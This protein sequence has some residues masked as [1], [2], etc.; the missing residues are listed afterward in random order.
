LTFGD[1]DLLWDLIRE[2]LGQAKPEE[3]PRRGGTRRWGLLIPAFVGPNGNVAPV[4]T[5][6]ALEEEE[7]VPHLVTA[8]P[9]T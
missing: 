3:K 7:A 5:A 8:F 4:L 1:G 2:Q 9:R 6:W